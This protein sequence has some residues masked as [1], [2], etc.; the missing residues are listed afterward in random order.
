MA[1]RRYPPQ[2]E[3]EGSEYSFEKVLKEDF[4]S[5]NALYRNQAGAGMVLKVSDCRFILGFLFKPLAAMLSRHE[6]KVYARLQ[7]I[8]GIPRLGPN[9]GWNGFFHEFVEGHTLYEHK[10]AD[11]LPSEFFDRLLALM[12]ELHAHGVIHLDS[13]KR[14]NMIVGRDGKPYII[15]FQISLIFGRMDGPLR[16]WKRRVFRALERE[17]IYH[18]YKRKRHLT[19]DDMTQEEMLLAQRSSANRKIKRWVGDPY[20]K[21]KRLV[22]PRGS[23]E[24]VWYRHKKL[25]EEERQH[26]D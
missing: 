17:D 23:N 18:V 16:G 13:N 15:D 24:T 3:F 5:I 12:R 2:I 25:R 22:Y 6:R 20:R 7:G 10:R 21:V 4:F 1:R 14:G 26:T 9:Y 11:P 8:A 19:P